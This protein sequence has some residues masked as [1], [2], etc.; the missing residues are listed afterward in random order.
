MDNELR[1]FVRHR[2]GDRCEYCRTRQ[3]NDPFFTFPIDHIIARQHG[4]QTH[5]GN[6]CLSCFRC[7]SRKGP[8]LASIDPETDSLVK[9]FHPRTDQW[10]DHFAWVGVEIVGKTPVGRATASLL[11]MNSPNIL[12]LRK[13][14]IEKGEAI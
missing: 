1:R 6:L 14:L 4:G 12:R 10:D 7:N 9:L 11:A 13:A 3:V 2:A 8:N 5:E